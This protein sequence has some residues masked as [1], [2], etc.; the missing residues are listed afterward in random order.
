MKIDREEPEGAFTTAAPLQASH[1]PAYKVSDELLRD[2]KS[3]YSQANYVA[4]EE[5]SR[6]ESV[7]SASLSPL[8]PGNVTPP[9]SFIVGKGALRDMLART[10]AIIVRIC[11]TANVEQMQ[12]PLEIA[13]RFL[14]KLALIS[15]DVGGFEWLYALANLVIDDAEGTVNNFHVI[16]TALTT[17]ADLLVHMI[18][19][20]DLEGLTRQGVKKVFRVPIYPLFSCG[21]S[22]G[23]D[24]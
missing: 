16:D 24:T 9:L 23:L 19:P 21:N 6:R 22:L 3:F 17:I 10:Q 5:R 7:S 15:P 20:L 12:D 1:P 8:P 4:L 11:E 14:R 2:A 18:T 13:C